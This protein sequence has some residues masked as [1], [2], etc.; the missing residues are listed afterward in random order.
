MM[1][2]MQSVVFVILLWIS[3]KFLAP[4]GLQQVV[5]TEAVVSKAVVNEVEDEGKRFYAIL[6]TTNL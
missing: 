4:S 2:R 5:S 6:K 1:E 3:V